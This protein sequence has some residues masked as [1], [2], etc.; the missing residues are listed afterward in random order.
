DHSAMPE[1]RDAKVEIAIPVDRTGSDDGDVHRVDESSIVVRHLA[2]VQRHVMTASTIVLAP[3]VTGKMPTEQME[4]F[5][6]RIALDRC[7][8]GHRQAGADL[9]VRGRV[10]SCGKRLV[11]LI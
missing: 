6:F 11:E 10:G 8:R 9:D 1:I 2:Q 7:T 4:V 3:F 5:S